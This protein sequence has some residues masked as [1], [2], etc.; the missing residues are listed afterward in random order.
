MK[1]TD[2]NPSNDMVFGVYDRGIV[3]SGVDKKPIQIQIPRVYAPF[4]LSGFPNQFGPVKYNI[5]A[6]LR[7]WNEEG[8]YMN[9]FYTFLRDIELEV[10]DHV[11]ALNIVG[12]HPEDSFNSNLK[13]SEKYDPKFRIKIDNK[14][15]FFDGANND[16]TPSELEDGLFKGRSFTALVELKNVYFFNK[17]MGLTWTIV[18]AK[19]F[20]QQTPH[21]SM[22]D[23][24]PEKKL[25]KFQFQI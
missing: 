6:S 9:K 19:V 14:T 2:F 21:S 25:S 7:G 13:I 16:I 24:V 3:L 1:F 15:A 18:Q 10:V 5:D 20:D 23:D 22:G 8:S 4:G 12:P 11:R 17:R